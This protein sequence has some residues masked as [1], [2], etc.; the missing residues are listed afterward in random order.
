MKCGAQLQDGARFCSNCG[1]KV[2]SSSGKVMD[3]KMLTEEQCEEVVGMLRDA[4]GIGR[5]GTRVP[6]YNNRDFFLASTFCA[7]VKTDLF[8]KRDNPR[9]GLYGGD[10]E[11]RRQWAGEE[12]R[13]II[14]A[15]FGDWTLTIN[16]GHGEGC[17][18][19]CFRLRYN[20]ATGN[21]YELRENV[22][23]TAVA[24]YRALED[25]GILF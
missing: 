12:L 18:A 13:Q 21:W 1:T 2:G 25:S 20:N 19:M 14:N 23:N 5:Y 11:K 15:N 9:I 6:F 17:D 8:I 22:V 7:G 4:I 10:F 16:E 3:E 24:V